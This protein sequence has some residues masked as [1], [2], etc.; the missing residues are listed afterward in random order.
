MACPVLNSVIDP[1]V[2]AILVDPE[3][4]PVAGKIE[5]GVG[6]F[7]ANTPCQ[8]HGCQMIKYPTG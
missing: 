1:V 8:L 7:G 4:S 6:R 2:W 3:V 5:R